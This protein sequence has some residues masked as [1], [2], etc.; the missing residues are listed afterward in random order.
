MSVDFLGIVNVIA[1]REVVKELLQK[2]ATGEAIAAELKRLLE[3]TEA[4]EALQA[5]LAE[6]RRSLGGE[7]AHQNAAN[8]V[9]SLVRG[10]T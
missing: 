8:A 1:G 9:A 6:I 3:D 2:E 10:E 4:R 5:E 7:G